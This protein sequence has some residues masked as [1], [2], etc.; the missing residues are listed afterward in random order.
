MRVFRAREAQAEG[1]ARRRER[2]WRRFGERGAIRR[3]RFTA[4]GAG[5]A[6]GEGRAEDGEEVN[7]GDPYTG[8]QSTAY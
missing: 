2:G 7:L 1:P 4:E 6:E 8:E 5:N 3:K